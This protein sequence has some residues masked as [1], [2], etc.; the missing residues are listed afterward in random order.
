MNGAVSLGELVLGLVAL[1]GVGSGFVGLFVL[2][3]EFG[4]LVRRVDDT[5][6][7]LEEAER[8]L[9]RINARD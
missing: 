1:L 2:R 7:R 3:V 5:E 8:E 4:P 9:A 6:R